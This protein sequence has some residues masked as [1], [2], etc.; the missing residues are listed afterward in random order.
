MD[1]DRRRNVPLIPRVACNLARGSDHRV[2][3]EGRAHALNEEISP[4]R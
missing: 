2:E 3:Y 1:Y 4:S